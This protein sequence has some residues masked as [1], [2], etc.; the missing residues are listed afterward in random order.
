ME[1]AERTWYA[2]S[3][4]IFILHRTHF[5]SF[6]SMVGNVQGAVALHFSVY[7]GDYLHS[8]GPVSGPKKV[9]EEIERT[10]FI[11]GGP[12]PPPTCRSQASLVAIARNHG[13]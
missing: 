2:S 11:H 6:Q 12:P 1:A 4:W 3:G 8:V 5:F 7:S 9:E 10:V 13:V